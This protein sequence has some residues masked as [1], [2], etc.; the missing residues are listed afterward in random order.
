[1][2]ASAITV[3][4]KS[5]PPEQLR[6]DFNNPR[7]TDE[8]GSLPST[9]DE[10]IDFFQRTADLDELLHSIAENGYLPFDDIVVVV[11]EPNVYRVLE[12]NRRLAAVRLYK[13]REIAER[14]KIELPTI[15]AEKLATLNSIPVKVVTS[16]ADA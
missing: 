14:L 15:T 3:L 9:E 12:G 10:M 11:I 4:P 7:L 1:M 8:V 2:A 16:E 6:F 5:V 13:N